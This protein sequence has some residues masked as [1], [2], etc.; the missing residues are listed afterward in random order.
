[1]QSPAVLA[2]ARLALGGQTQQT[3]SN[4]VALRESGFRGEIEE[5]VRSDSPPS[6]KDSFDPVAMAHL[7]L[8]Y[9]ANNPRPE[10]DYE[11]RFSFFML[12]QPIL[13][14]YVPPTKDLLDPVTLGDTE[15]RMDTAFILMREMT[16][17]AAGQAAQDGVRRRIL[18][19]LRDD[20][21]C[22]LIPYCMSS[23]RDREYAMSWTTG[24]LLY[25]LAHQYRLT[26]DESVK[27]LGKKVLAGLKSMATWDTGRAFYAHG[28][29][30]WHPQG[31]APGYHG[32]YPFVVEPVL[33]WYEASG[34]EEAFDFGLAMAEGMV[35]NLQ[36]NHLHRSDGF[37]GGHTHVQMHAVSGVAHLGALTRDPRHIEWAR[38]FYDLIRVR[39]LETGWVPEMSD[40]GFN[41]EYLFHSLHCETCLVAD[42]TLMAVYLARS[43]YTSYWDHVE[44]TLRNY[45]QAVQFRVT[46]RLEEFYGT[47]HPDRDK[48]RAGLAEMR[49]LQGGF[50]ASPTPNDWV[51]SVPKEWRHHGMF[52]PE[53]L[54]MD[55]MGCCPP[56]GMRALHAGWQNAVVEQ[57]DAVRVNLAIQRDAAPARV[58]PIDSGR[59]G[60]RVT[61]RSAKRYLLRVPAWADRHAVRAQRGDR[62]VPCLWKGDS[63]CFDGVSAGEQLEISYPSRAFRQSCVIGPKGWEQIYVLS[64][65]GNVCTGIAPSGRYMPMFA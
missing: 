42:M 14:P 4:G 34:D 9:L 59:R 22:W 21:L 57:A 27:K 13:V 10:R 61:A 11:T 35:Q 38:K 24:K 18:K 5:M 52:G 29:Q 48:A 25:S 44:R 36:P 56:E 17:S 60:I 45:L 33:T 51:F 15:S 58:T 54:V 7:A 30:P 12:N 39:G 8:D 23:A 31:P 64:W 32:H 37:V 50:M 28:C 40:L 6:A 19:Y 41:R 46:P 62:E 16:E 55:M 53:R 3:R 49:K 47:L 2:A 1:M 26:H 63:I 20:G 65:Q 43:G